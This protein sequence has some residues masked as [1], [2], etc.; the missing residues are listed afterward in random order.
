MTGVYV[1]GVGSQ[2]DTGM[3]LVEAFKVVQAA[4]AKTCHPPIDDPNAESWRQKS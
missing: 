4:N 1:Y 3:A 2:A